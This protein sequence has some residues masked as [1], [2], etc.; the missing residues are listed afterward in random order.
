MQDDHDTKPNIKYRPGPKQFGAL[1]K[2]LSAAPL[3]CSTVL[4][5]L[6]YIYSQETL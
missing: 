6:V 3:H 1:G 2:I 5:L 4:A